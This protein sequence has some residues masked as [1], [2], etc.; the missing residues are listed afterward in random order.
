M[1]NCF[2]IIGGNLGNRR[3]NLA[4]AIQY[5]EKKAGVIKRLSSVYE[6]APWGVEQQPDYYNQVIEMLTPL[7]ANELMAT[8][9]DVEK[10]MGRVRSEKYG[11]RTIDIDILFFNDDFVNHIVSFIDININFQFDKTFIFC[12]KHC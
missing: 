9:L 4:T 7:G 11:A 8:L 10:E 3:L 2:L 6:T 5:I 1:N 12:T